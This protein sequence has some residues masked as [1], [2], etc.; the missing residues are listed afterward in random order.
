M[1]LQGSKFPYFFLGVL[2]TDQHEI[3]RRYNFWVF[4][5][6]VKIVS[7]SFHKNVQNTVLKMK[8]P[9]H[10]VVLCV[11]CTVTCF[12]TAQNKSA[13]EIYREVSHVHNNEHY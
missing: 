9:F 2:W 8:L 11:V 7:Q 3:A 10:V 6:T 1:K 5:N 4:G 12:F 13:V